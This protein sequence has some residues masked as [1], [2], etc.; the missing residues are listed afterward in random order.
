MFQ[1]HLKK[2]CAWIALT[3]LGLAC[4]QSNLRFSKTWMNQKWLAKPIVAA[5]L[6][7][8]CPENWRLLIWIMRGRRKKFVGPQLL[9]HLPKRNAPARIY[10]DICS[11]L[12]NRKFKNGVYQPTPPLIATPT[13][14]KERSGSLLWTPWTVW[15]LFDP[16]LGF[17]MFFSF[18][19]KRTWAPLMSNTWIIEVL[20]F[21]L[22]AGTFQ[23]W[24][25]N[26]RQTFL[27]GKVWST[28]RGTWNWHKWVRGFLLQASAS[29][30]VNL[31]SCIVLRGNFHPRCWQ[32]CPNR[33]GKNHWVVLPKIH[34]TWLQR[35]EAST[36]GISRFDF[37]SELCSRPLHFKH[38]ILSPKH[39]VPWEL[40]R[41]L[42]IFYGKY[43]GTVSWQ[44]FCQV[45]GDR[46]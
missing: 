37:N 22:M 2:S 17:N 24:G 35:W 16:D 10:D 29:L 30:Q 14:A 19:V 1:A 45:T 26:R 28:S 12:G 13:T 42:V 33:L 38:E 25:L 8:G 46:I 39:K 11:F 23:Y 41:Y 5:S 4:Q 20:S 31:Q 36:I 40:L 15:T 18:N 21:T 27:T 6:L 7:N 3:V 32:L 44:D 9:W 34:V 43:E